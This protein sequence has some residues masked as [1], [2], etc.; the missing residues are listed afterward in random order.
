MRIFDPFIQRPGL[1]LFVCATL[2]GLAYG[3]GHEREIV[4]VPYWFSGNM[5]RFCLAL[6]VWTALMQR[7]PLQM[8]AWSVTDFV[9]LSLPFFAGVLFAPS[10]Q[11]PNLIAYEIAVG[12]VAAGGVFGVTVCQAL[13]SLFFRSD[14]PESQLIPSRESLSV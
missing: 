12:K 2:F 1:V 11:M 9:V 3:L 6:M 8:L 13:I 14:K 10:M 4:P 7:T 5:Y